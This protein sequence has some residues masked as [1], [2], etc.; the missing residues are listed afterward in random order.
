MVGTALHTTLVALGGI[1]NSLER[2]DR[3]VV[4]CNDVI[5]AQEN[6]QFEGVHIAFHWIVD[7]SMQHYV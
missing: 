3:L 1:P 6:V 7:H 2:F 4:M 5:F